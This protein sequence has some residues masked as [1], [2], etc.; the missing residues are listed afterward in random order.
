MKCKQTDTDSTK[1]TYQWKANKPIQTVQRS[2]TNVMQRIRILF[3]QQD[4]RNARKDP[5]YTKFDNKEKGP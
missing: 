2:R 3:L 1:I 4:G 5:L